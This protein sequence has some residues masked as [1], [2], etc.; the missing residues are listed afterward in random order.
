MKISLRNDWQDKIN[1]KIKVYL[2][3]I[4]DKEVVNKVFN[5]LYE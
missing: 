2:L 5:E 1:I 3:G 4:K